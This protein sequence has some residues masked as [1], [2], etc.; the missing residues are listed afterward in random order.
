MHPS[1]EQEL[2]Q[3]MEDNHESMTELKDFDGRRLHVV[4][5]IPFIV[6]IQEIGNS[7]IRSVKAVWILALMHPIDV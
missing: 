5:I 7:L 3:G 1:F 4:A 2:Q 6:I